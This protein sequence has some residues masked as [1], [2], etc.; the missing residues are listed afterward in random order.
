VKELP[1]GKTAAGANP[2][3]PFAV[4]R[5]GVSRSGLV[6]RIEKIGI[7]LFGAAI[8]AA[9]TV[10]YSGHVCSDCGVIRE[11]YDVLGIPILQWKTPTRLTELLDRYGENPSHSHR[12]VE[13]GRSSVF[14]NSSGDGASFVGRI[15]NKNVMDFLDGMYRFEDRREARRWGERLMGS[16]ESASRF[17]EVLGGFQVQEIP[18]DETG[19]RSWWTE[20]GIDLEDAVFSKAAPVP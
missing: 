20:H 5:S 15:M 6:K 9:L 11:S 14:S 8:L 19:W 7:F 2:Q 18:K 13:R 1:Q 10:S 12:Y 4:L 16:G 3:G 17:Q